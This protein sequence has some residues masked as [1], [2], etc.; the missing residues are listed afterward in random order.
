MKAMEL[1]V[2]QE[3]SCCKISITLIEKGQRLFSQGLPSADSR[4]RLVFP[5]GKRKFFL[6]RER[7]RFAR[8]PLSNDLRALARAVLHS[9]LA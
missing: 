2:A 5:S 7:A 6:F 4:T 8:C 9:L 1:A 3:D